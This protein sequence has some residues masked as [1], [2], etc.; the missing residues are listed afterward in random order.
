MYV[1]TA[2]LSR[3]SCERLKKVDIQERYTL[4][5]IAQAMQPNEDVGI[6]LEDPEVDK[7]ATKI[8]A[9]FKGYKVRK[10]M[11]QESKVL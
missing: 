8:Q 10:E 4:M 1:S 5:C 11:K 9:G 2:I 7:A 3:L 6:D